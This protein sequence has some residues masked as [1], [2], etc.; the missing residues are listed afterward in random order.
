MGDS[1][2]T[3]RAI[4]VGGAAIAVIAAAIYGLWVVVIVLGIGIIAHGLLWWYLLR[5]QRRDQA[6]AATG[7]PPSQRPRA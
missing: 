7:A 5:Q 2:N 3:L 6:T 1:L 4:L